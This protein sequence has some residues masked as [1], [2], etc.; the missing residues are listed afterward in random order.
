GGIPWQRVLEPEE[1]DVP[2]NVVPVTEAGLAKEL[3]TA[4][5]RGFDLASELPLRA[6]L[7]ELGPQDH[8]LLLAMHHIAMDGWSLEPLFRD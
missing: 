3:A 7:F 1:V 8:V 6:W 4:A 5:G 2:L